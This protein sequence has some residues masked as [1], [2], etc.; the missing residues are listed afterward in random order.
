LCGQVG[1]VLHGSPFN[2]SVTESTALNEQKF[3]NF[4]YSQTRL[5]TKI[6]EILVLQIAVQHIGVE[7]SSRFA[8]PCCITEQSIPSRW[9]LEA[10]EKL[11]S[12][13]KNFCWRRA[14]TCALIS[15][16]TLAG[17]AQQAAPPA[18][19]T[20]GIQIQNMDRSVRPGDDFYEYANGG[21]IK[22]TEI[23]P[24]RS[25]VGVWTVLEDLANQRTQAL[26]EEIARSNAGV[27]SNRRKIADLYDSYMRED[28]IEKKGLSPIQPQ[29]DAIARINDRKELSRAL[30][31]SL[32]NDVDPLNNTNFHTENLFGF[33]LGPGFSDPDHYTGYLLQGGLALPDREYYLSGSPHMKNLREKYQAHVSAILKL[34]RFTDTDARAARIVALER[35]IAETHRSRA[36]NDDI[37]KASNV[38]RLSD[39]AAKAP[40]LDWSEYFRAAGL[41]GQT[42][43]YVWQPEAFTGEA[44]LVN[45]QSMDG[46][47]DWLAFHLIQRYGGI[48]PKK[49]ADERFAFFG[50]ELSGTPQQRP[51]WQRAVFIVNDLLGDAV[52]QI[53]AERYFS[54]RAKVEAQQMVSNIIEAFRKRIDALSWM[55]PGTKAE[56]KAKLDTLYVG[57]GYPEKWRDYTGYEVR[58]D[59]LFGNSRRAGLFQYR[60]DLRRLGTNVDKHEWFMTPQTVNALNLPLQNA[61]NFP[62]A[63]LQPPFF[64]ADAPAAVNYGAIGS[65]I[66]HEISHSFDSSG[67]LFDSKGRLRNWWTFA[68]MKHFEESTARLIAQYNTY[69]PFPDLA[70]NGRQTLAENVADLAGLAASYDGWKAS[71]GNKLPALQDGL[72]GDEQLFIADAQIWGMK[73]REPLLRELVLTDGH[74]PGQYRSYAVRNIDAWYDSFRVQPGDKLYLPP[75]DRVRIW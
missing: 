44:A 5:P 23:P 40:G 46:W 69:K 35:A 18:P 50:T 53:Y 32:R 49:I 11:R 2:G 51:R 28:V 8:I 38:W 39:F 45:S 27:G 47:K 13:L 26:V 1:L 75:G 24:D 68:D 71:L 7:S 16:V 36:E 74:S 12:E 64:D 34:A 42:Q 21:W 31:E 65:I 54:A 30:G 6:A 33:W 59:D 62:A 4:S 29:L 22:R 9:R 55:D 63:I 58:A 61:L 41:A 52:G 3:N 20:H 19:A 37:N 56:A 15:C 25:D 73:I 72:A 43:L 17:F 60:C 70:V 14:T 10:M 48:L 66:G 67:A 57:L